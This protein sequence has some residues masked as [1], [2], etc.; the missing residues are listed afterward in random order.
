MARICWGHSTGYFIYNFVI[1]LISGKHCIERV[2]LAIWEIFLHENIRNYISCRFS[3][4]FAFIHFLCCGTNQKQE[5][6]FQQDKRIFL[7]VISV[8]II[9]SW[10]K[11]ISI[12]KLFRKNCESCLDLSK[13]ADCRFYKLN[14]RF[15]VLWKFCQLGNTKNLTLWILRGGAGVQYIFAVFSYL[16]HFCRQCG[17]YVNSSF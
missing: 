12:N 17:T 9:V 13:A 14:T 10:I 11:L 7:H 16:L 4:K 8:R 1:Q 2:L 15:H 5:S 6:S 3:H